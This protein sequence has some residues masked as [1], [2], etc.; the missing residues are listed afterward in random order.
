MAYFHPRI[1]M[2]HLS[3][4]PATDR[5]NSLNRAAS[6]GNTARF[7]VAFLNYRKDILSIPGRNWLY[8]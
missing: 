8:K 5:N 6:V 1:G 4:N 3:E 2:V 7:F